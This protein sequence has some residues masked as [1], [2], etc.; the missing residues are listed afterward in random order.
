VPARRWHGLPLTRVPATRGLTSRDELPP[1]RAVQGSSA[2][3]CRPPSRL[4]RGGSWLLT[5]ALTL[6][7]NNTVPAHSF[8]DENP[9]DPSKAI[10]P[11]GRFI[12]GLQDLLADHE[13]Q[14]GL[15][16]G[17]LPRTVDLQEEGAK[18][19]LQSETFVTESPFSRLLRAVRNGTESPTNARYG[20]V[21]LSSIGG[22]AY[23]AVTWM[24][25]MLS[26][27]DPQLIV[28][29]QWLDTGGMH[30]VLRPLVAPE[31]PKEEVIQSVWI[32]E[33]PVPNSLRYDLRYVLAP[34]ETGRSDW[35]GFRG[36][37]PLQGRSDLVRWTRTY[38][39]ERDAIS[40][41]ASP[42]SSIPARVELVRDGALAW[43]LSLTWVKV[44]RGWFISSATQV[45][46][47]PAGPKEVRYFETLG[48]ELTTGSPRIQ[49]PHPG[50]VAY[51]S[52]PTGEQFRTA[53]YRSWPQWITDLVEVRE[54][55][56]PGQTP[57]R[58]EPPWLAIALLSVGVLLF[59][60]VARRRYQRASRGATGSPRNST[61]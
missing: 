17:G 2:P 28:P 34:L 38:G 19:P 56:S 15:W 55:A 13:W 54:A 9:G 27:A 24:S 58:S 52:D 42:D 48:L 25:G 30:L 10:A 11:W 57:A 59:G 40:V 1:G 3:L 31:L 22:R 29:T 12:D 26:K 50:T 45:L 53:G 8:A 33:G 37:E 18:R 39:S 51:A 4:G 60:V 61:G 21:V 35:T 32:T 5:A 23:S 36:P 20:T 7:L 41:D 44:A 47:G 43:S 16:I 14:F 49:L 6:G 46:H